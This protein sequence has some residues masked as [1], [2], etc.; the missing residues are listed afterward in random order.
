VRVSQERTWEGRLFQI[1]GAAERKPRAPNEMLQ[2]VIYR[3]LAEADRR[4][5]H[6]VCHLAKY[7]L[8]MWHN[9]CKHKTG[10]S[11]VPHRIVKLPCHSAA[12]FTWRSRPNLMCNWVERPN[13]HAVM[14]ASWATGLLQLAGMNDAA[15]TTN[16][17]LTTDESTNVHHSAGGHRKQCHECRQSTQWTTELKHVQ[18]VSS[19]LSL[20]QSCPGHTVVMSFTTSR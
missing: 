6:G 5:L 10:H 12:S 15:A 11:S 7:G 16:V 20:C 1:V 3:R 8:Y 17:W 4:V 2:R 18:H 19:Y 14:W 13:T 9:K